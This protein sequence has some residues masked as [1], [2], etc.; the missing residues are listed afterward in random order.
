MMGKPIE[1]AVPREWAERMKQLAEHAAG[2]GYELASEYPNLPRSVVGQ[3][4]A[5][6]ILPFFQHAAPTARQALEA[7]VQKKGNRDGRD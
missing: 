5:A 2:F 3:A 7:E 4:V 6:E 1:G